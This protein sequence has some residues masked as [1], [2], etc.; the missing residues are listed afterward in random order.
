MLEV[1]TWEHPTVNMIGIGVTPEAERRQ[2]HLR[3]VPDDKPLKTI[4]LRCLETYSERPTAR[5]VQAFLSRL[6]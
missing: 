5:E 6:T 4:I 3:K 1:E 2:S